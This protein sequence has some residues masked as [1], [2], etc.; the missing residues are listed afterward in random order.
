[1][2]VAEPLSLKKMVMKKFSFAFQM[3]MINGVPGQFL[4]DI[5]IK[6]LQNE[7]IFFLISRNIIKK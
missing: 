3:E 5:I 6:I 7:I 4:N 1:M 2:V